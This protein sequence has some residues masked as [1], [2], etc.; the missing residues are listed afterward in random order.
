MVDAACVIWT[1][2]ND[3]RSGYGRKWDPKRQKTRPLTHLVWEEANGP[4][5]EGLEVCHT[6]DTPA[7]YNIEHLFLGTH[8]DNMR[9]RSAKGRFKNKWT[10]AIYCGRG[11][12]HDEE[13]T[14]LNSK[15][16]R[17]CR[18]CLRERNREAYL[19]RKARGYYEKKAS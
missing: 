6:C 13:N 2:A 8:S 18:Q 11:H 4:V 19:R 3:G 15:G 10:E 14:Y 9:D 7:C 17:V 16:W 1:G 5:P 12:L